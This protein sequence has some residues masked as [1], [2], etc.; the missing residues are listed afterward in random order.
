MEP[1]IHTE[2]RDDVRVLRME[3]G[4]ANALSPETCAAVSAALDAD[5]APTVLTGEGSVFSAGLN[6]IA[7]EPLEREA[8]ERF[9]EAFSVMMVRALA[10]PYP[11]VAAVNGHAV[12][13]GCVLAMACDHRIGVAGDYKIGMNEIAIGLTLPAIVTEILRGKLTADHAHDVILGGALYA[14]E[15]ALD[16]GLIDHLVSSPEEAVE[17]A[18]HEA[19]EL[20]RSPR[21]FAAMKG[22]LVSP[23]VERFRG[24]RE[25]LDRRFVDSWFG[26]HASA[27]RRETIA[28]LRDHRAGDAARD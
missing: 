4:S 7:L 3:F 6:L 25:A 5:P 1:A 16:V 12:A 17:R 19:T 26:E 23:I 14:P 2:H 15:A 22:S 9:I 13:G 18:C 28:R 8:M 20:Y 27:A 21:E 10:A 24:T 11:L